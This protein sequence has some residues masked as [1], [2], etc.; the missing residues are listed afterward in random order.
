M[1][2]PKLRSNFLRGRKEQSRSDNQKQRK[3][4]VMLLHRVKQQCFS[5][6][7]PNSIAHNIDIVKSTF[8]R[9]SSSEKNIR[10]NGK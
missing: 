6:V 9:Q 5:S 7:D 1:T 2:G 4:C 3:T 10:F 8:L